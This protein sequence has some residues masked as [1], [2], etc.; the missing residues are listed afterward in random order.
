MRRVH[1]GHRLA[2]STAASPL[3][4]NIMSISELGRVIDSSD[5]WIRRRIGIRARRFA[6]ELAV[7]GGLGA[8]S[9]PI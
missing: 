2:W 9:G 1:A 5:E 3:W 6:D 8:S 4:D 7:N